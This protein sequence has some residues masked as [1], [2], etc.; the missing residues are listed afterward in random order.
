M[1]ALLEENFVSARS[2]T[3][4]VANAGVSPGGMVEQITRVSSSVI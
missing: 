2:G 4:T 1:M 3:I